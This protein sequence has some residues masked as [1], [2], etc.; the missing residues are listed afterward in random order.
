[1]SQIVFQPH[2]FST[3]SLIL[4]YR[5]LELRQI[6]K[7]VLSSLRAKHLLIS[8]I[9]K[10]FGQKLRY[11]NT[12]VITGVSF[13]DINKL[14]CPG[15]SERLIFKIF[16]KCH[17]QRAAVIP[18]ILLQKCH[19]PFAKIS[20]G[21]IADPSKRDIIS[22]QDHS[23]IAKRI[24]YFHASVELHS[25]IDGIRDLLFY[26]A[27]LY[28]SGYIVGSVKNCHVLVWHAHSLKNKH[29]SCYPVCFICCAWSKMA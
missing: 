29:L 10:D 6:I 9:L 17:V 28:C 7:P 14:F 2:F 1:M 11:R 4:K 18:C 5:L 22:I 27:C 8:G 3:G 21:H 15:S 26:K 16:T 19:T 25:R 24:L 20:L 12:L 23:K 13:N